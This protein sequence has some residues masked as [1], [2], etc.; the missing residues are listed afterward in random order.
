MAGTL[1]RVLGLACLNFLL[2]LLFSNNSVY[3]QSIVRNLPGF[4]G[5]LPFKLETGYVITYH[6]VVAEP[7]ILNGD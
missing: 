1:G 4:H 5:D 2:L 6:V 3:S 7:E